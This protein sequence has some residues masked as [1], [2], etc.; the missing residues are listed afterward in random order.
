VHVRCTETLKQGLGRIPRVSKALER[1]THDLCAPCFSAGK[2]QRIDG[3]FR[4]CNHAPFAGLL[5]QGEISSKD[6]AQTHDI[7]PHDIDPHGT[8]RQEMSARV[9]WG[10]GLGGEGAQSH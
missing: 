3:G 4:A 1:T 5:L 7:D 8:G 9:V 2:Y 10:V 6:W